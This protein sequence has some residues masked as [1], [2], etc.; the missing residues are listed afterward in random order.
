[1]GTEIATANLE[2]RV[3]SGIIRM[4]DR[5]VRLHGHAATSV[6]GAPYCRLGPIGVERIL[7]CA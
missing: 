5:L 7:E 3:M 6:N 1:M 2:R 4:W